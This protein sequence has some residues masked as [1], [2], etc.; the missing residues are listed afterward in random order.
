VL[1]SGSGLGWSGILQDGIHP[2]YTS[3]EV[4]V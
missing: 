4:Y 3:Q 2:L 1:M